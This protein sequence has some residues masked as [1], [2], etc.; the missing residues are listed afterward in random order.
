MKK[1]GRKESAA[2]RR[3]G[4][5][6]LAAAILLLLFG[7]AGCAK[8]TKVP[9]AD[10]GPQRIVILPFSVPE[11]DPELQWAAMA[12]PMLMARAGTHYPDFV[13]TPLWES[14]PTAIAAA[15]AARSFNDDSAT[16]VANWLGAHWTVMGSITRSK[17][18]AYSLVVDFI[19]AKSSDVPYRYIKTR[20]M[21]SM[22]NAMLAS[23]RQ[24]LRF[25]TGRIHPLPRVKVP[26]L[27]RVRPEGE[28]LDREYGWFVEAA[29]GSAGTI[30]NDMTL[31]DKELARLLFNP[32]LYPGL[33]Q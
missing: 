6:T 10:V 21:D 12:L 30:V 19:P 26:G 4:L 24:F 2:G 31:T 28:A 25:S 8:K 3:A 29:P 1:C 11:D 15:G 14:M 20:K 17:G 16:A 18:S 23:I 22:G 5:P 33:A 13:V 7:Q 32:T 27:D 9:A